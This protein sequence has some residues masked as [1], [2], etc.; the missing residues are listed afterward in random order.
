MK[1]MLL[2]SLVLLVAFVLIAATPAPL[3]KVAGTL[4]YSRGN[5]CNMPDYITL[6]V[7]QN[8]YLK[9][10]MFPTSGQYANC[11]IVAEG[12]YELSTSTSPQCRVFDVTRASLVCPRQ[13]P[14]DL[15]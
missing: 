8:L 7:M 1:K 11:R 12:H 4:Q 13:D 5:I 10:F 9:G 2:V 15:R 6:P 3:Q 14:V